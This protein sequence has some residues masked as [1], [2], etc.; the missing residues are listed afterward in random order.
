MDA[1]AARVILA[2]LYKIEERLVDLTN[3]M[4]DV[5]KQINGTGPDRVPE[6][7]LP[8]VEKEEPT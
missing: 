6:S 5:R 2:R 3:V 4:L 1:D 7:W 8:F